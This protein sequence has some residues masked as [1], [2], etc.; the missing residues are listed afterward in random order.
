MTT[1]DGQQVTLRDL[2]GK[3]VLVTFWATSCPSCIAEM[4]HLAALHEDLHGEGL[5]IIGVAMHHDPP[6]RVAALVE[7]RDLPYT[8]VLDKDRS[9]ARAFGGIG[10]TPTSYLITPNGR[11]VQRTIG[12]FDMAKLRSRVE[13]ML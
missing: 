1:L 13:G 9:V 10:V 4:P 5:E 3:P 2:H 8:I 12:E 7:Q 6:E 11:V